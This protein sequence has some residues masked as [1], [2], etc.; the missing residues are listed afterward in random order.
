MKDTVKPLGSLIDELNKIREAKRVLEE[1]VKEQED[2][3]KELEERLMARLEAEGTDKATG[4]TATASV[5]T[6]VSFSIKDD[7]KFFAWMSRTKNYHLMQRR[8]SDPAAREVME[9]KRSEIPGLEAFSK[10]RLNLRAL[11]PSVKP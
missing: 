5:S 3:Y 4:K 1:K 8:I 10:K 7:T 6:S 11:K 2:A 9:M